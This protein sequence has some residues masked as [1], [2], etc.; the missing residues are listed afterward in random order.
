MEG[1]VSDLTSWIA[2]LMRENYEAVGFLP[3]GPP[4][5]ALEA[6]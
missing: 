6:P 5:L 2:G 4:A 1:I 3:F